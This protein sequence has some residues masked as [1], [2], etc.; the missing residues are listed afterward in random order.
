LTIYISW[1]INGINHPIKR[2][3]ILNFL[4]SHQAQVAL[5][6]E[7]HLTQI[8][9]EKLRRGWVG[10]CFYSSY[11]SKARGVAI[12]INKNSP[13]HLVS[14]STDSN[15]RYIIVHGRWGSRP[16]T[17]VSVYAPNTDDPLMVQN[18]FLKLAQ[19]P[20]PWII[21]GD[22]NCLL[23]TVMDRSSSTLTPCSYMAQAI[24]N[25][26][27]EC[28]L[29]DIWRHLHPR[30]R[31]YSHYSHA[32][33]SLSRIDLFLISSSLIHCVQDCNF[34][35]RY[36]S[37]HSPVCVRLETSV[38]LQSSYRWR[39][40]SQLLTREDSIGE[41]KAAIQ[42]FFHFNNS[43]SSPPDIVWE[44]FKATIRGKVIALSSAHKKAFQ[45]QT[46]DLERDLRGAEAELYKNNSPENRERVATLQHELNMLS[47]SRAE[48]AILRSRSRFYARGDKPGKMLPWQLR[49]EEASCLIPSIRLPDG[50]LSFSP[51]AVNE[52]FCNYY[53]TLYSTQWGGGGLRR[54]MT[55]FLDG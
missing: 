16:I 22:F 23:D 35:P 38:D 1:N 29:T 15:G 48:R 12:L 6:Q 27:E 8:E 53:A 41:I 14:Q 39:F 33:K 26:M 17:L 37:D 34:L 5:L 21:G 30:T 13:F 3:R 46:I 28:S 36:I 7:T 50:A 47:S 40:D 54:S 2:K 31:E 24:V 11:S 4:S 44:A 51:G 32:H 19:Y 10:K 9:H 43:Q 55:T 42:E 52:A 45:Q 18:L 25:S 49:W 20:S